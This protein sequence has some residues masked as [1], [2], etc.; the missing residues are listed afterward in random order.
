MN[1]LF[2]CI[3]MR[4]EEQQQQQQKYAHFDRLV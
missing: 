3:V 1:V 2:N 4:V